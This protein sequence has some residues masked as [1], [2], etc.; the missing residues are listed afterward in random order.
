VA[1]L[2]RVASGKDDVNTIGLS[3]AIE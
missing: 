3:H 2:E 1:R